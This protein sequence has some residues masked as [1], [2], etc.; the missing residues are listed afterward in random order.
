MNFLTRT[1]FLNM[2][3]DSLWQYGTHIS[4]INK[5]Q[6]FSDTIPQKISLDDVHHN[7]QLG[8]CKLNLSLCGDLLKSSYL[9]VKCLLLHVHNS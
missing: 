7:G 2:D 4:R 8:T 1:V 3:L 6:Y 5:L 9:M